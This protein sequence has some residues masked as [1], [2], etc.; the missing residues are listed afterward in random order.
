[1]AISLKAYSN[2]YWE[3]AVSKVGHAKTNIIIF[4]SL[5]VKPSEGSGIKHFIMNE[6]YIGFTYFCKILTNLR[7]NKE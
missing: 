3:R 1:M 6:L 2:H 5:E 4:Q 7:H